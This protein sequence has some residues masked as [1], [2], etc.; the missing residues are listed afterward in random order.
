MG[1]ILY[2]ERL[3]KFGPVLIV[4]DDEMHAELIIRGLRKGNREVRYKLVTDGQAALDYIFRESPS[5]SDE[6]NPL[7]AL[8]LLDLS[9]PK[10]NGLEVLK[11]IKSDPNLCTIPVVMLSTSNHPKDIEASLKNHAN[12]YLTKPMG[13]DEFEVLLEQVTS[14]WF[15]VNRRPKSIS[16]N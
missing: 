14:Y 4:E 1:G 13:I 12:S 3:G 8:I 7:P 9:L 6:D 5:S 16:M 15:G 10:V 2:M 11:R